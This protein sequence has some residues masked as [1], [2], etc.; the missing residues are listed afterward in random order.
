MSSSIKCVLITTFINSGLLNLT[1][2]ATLGN[3][4]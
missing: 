3:E 1:T 4:I 2:A